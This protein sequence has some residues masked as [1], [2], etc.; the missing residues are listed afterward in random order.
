MRGDGLMKIRYMALFMLAILLL[1]ATAMAIQVPAYEKVKEGPQL[2]EKNKELERFNFIHYARNGG[3]SY[4]A[5]ASNKC[6]KLMGV[7]WGTLPVSYAINPANPD[8]L[9]ESF[10]T[11]AVSTSAETWDAATSK[12]LF[13]N[14]Y[15][16]DYSAV[17]GVY[18]SKNSVVFGAYPQSNVIAVTSVWYTRATRRI[19]EF[20]M[21]F[22]VYYDWGDATAASAVMDLQN[23]ATH[24][25]G[26]SVGLSDLYTTS[27]SAVTMYGY[28][29]YGETQ[30]RTLEQPDKT[31]LQKMYGT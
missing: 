16:V 17:Y 4:K 7:K 11:G 25:L 22:N 21:L 28:S 19:V 26:H 9:T 20:D 27:C 8:G 2:E 23:I 24:E 3:A 6:Y 30:K 14:Q 5:A 29:G 10:V 18:D 12:E 31:G 13:N 1:S 15:S